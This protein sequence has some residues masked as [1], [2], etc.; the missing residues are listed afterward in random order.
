MQWPL[1]RSCRPFLTKRRDSDDLGAGRG[2]EALLLPERRC[3]GALTE[4]S[5]IFTGRETVF[6]LAP[7]RKKLAKVGLNPINLGIRNLLV[8]V[9]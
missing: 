9:A 1:P 5:C 7:A 4:R 6:F 3:D 2:L 8:F